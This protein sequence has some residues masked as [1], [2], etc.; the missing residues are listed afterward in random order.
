MKYPEEAKEKGIE[1]RVALS[2][3]ISADGKVCDIKV[4]RGVDPIID[5]EA[6]RVLE[7]S[8]EW[9]PGYKDGKPIP[10]QFIFPV[11]FKLQ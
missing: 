8:P 3:T 5:N 4:V 7:S 1:G 2:F 6:V 10:I 11:I 9:T